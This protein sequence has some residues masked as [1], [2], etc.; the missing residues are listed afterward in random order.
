[1]HHIGAFD[2]G[3]SYDVRKRIPLSIFLDIGQS[4]Q[5]TL[6]PNTCIRKVINA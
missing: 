2:S 3:M 6:G 5:N 4:Q 1:V